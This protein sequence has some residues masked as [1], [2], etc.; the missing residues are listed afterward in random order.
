M[1]RRI[2]DINGPNDS[3]VVDDITVVDDIEVGGDANVVG[4]LAVGGQTTNTSGAGTVTT[5]ATTSAEEFGDGINHVTKLTLTAFSL[6]NGADNADLAIG[7]EVYTFP[8]GDL[9]IYDSSILGAFTSAASVTT[10]GDGEYGM[11]TVVG[12]TAVD[13]LAE[14]GATAENIMTGQ[15][16]STYVADGTS[17]VCHSTV[18][19]DTPSANGL[20]VR[21]SSGLAHKLFLNFA[22]TWP[23]VTAAA[24]FTF[25]GVITCRWRKIS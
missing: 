14:V 11:G 23:D 16:V 20:I 21:A 4:A 15:A 22:A 25:T 7:A 24:G 18:T 13:T 8:A 17:T 3:P 5:A 1:S 2:R 9:V 19:G 12:S 10:I 6:G